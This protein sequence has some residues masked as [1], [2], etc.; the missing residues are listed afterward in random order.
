MLITKGRWWTC[1]TIVLPSSSKAKAAQMWSMMSNI[2]CFSPDTAYIRL[3]AMRV[4]RS[5]H[6]HDTGVGS[7]CAVTEEPIPVFHVNR[8]ARTTD[9]GAARILRLPMRKR[10]IARTNG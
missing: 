4:P 3:C 2:G 1:L 7:T 6:P 10:P 9:T 8:E 5:L